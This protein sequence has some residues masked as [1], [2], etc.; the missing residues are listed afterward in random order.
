[1]GLSDAVSLEWFAL[2]I[3]SVNVTQANILWIVDCLKPKKFL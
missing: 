1:M 3:V 2:V